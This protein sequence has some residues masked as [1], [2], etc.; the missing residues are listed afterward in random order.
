[1]AKGGAESTTIDPTVQVL[2]DKLRAAKRAVQQEKRDRRKQAARRAERTSGVS[3]TSSATSSAQ[4]TQLPF[5]AA[6]TGLSGLFDEGGEMEELR[7]KLPFLP[8]ALHVEVGR[9]VQELNDAIIESASGS[10]QISKSDAARIPKVAKGHS[11]A[12]LRASA[13]P[14]HGS[15]RPSK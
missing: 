3:P 10:E 2:V 5:H 6:D 13:A 9:L 14:S 12:G 11:V 4:G 7:Q 8:A 1:M 15:K